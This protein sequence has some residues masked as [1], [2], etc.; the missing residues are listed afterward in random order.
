MAGCNKDLKVYVE[1]GFSHKEITV[2]CGST[3]PTGYPHL[4]VECEEL[5]KDVDWR[6]EAA[7][8]GETWGEDDY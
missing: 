2:Q 1:R 3:S 4:C 8:N 5:Y 6:K 7:L